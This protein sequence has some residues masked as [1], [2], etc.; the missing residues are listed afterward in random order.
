DV[1]PPTGHPGHR[2]WLCHQQGGPPPDAHRGG[3][4]ASRRRTRPRLHHPRR[5]WPRRSAGHSHRRRS[6]GP[7]APPRRDRRLLPR[8][9]RRRHGYRRRHLQGHRV[10]RRRRDDRLAVGRRQRGARSWL[11]LGD[12]H[13]PSDAAARRPGP[14]HHPGHA[15]GDPPR[16]GQRERR[17]AEPV[18]RAA[19]LDGDLRL[20]RC[21]GVPEGRGHGGPGAPD[22]GQ[23]VAEVPGRGDGPL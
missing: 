13:L 12:G 11:P 14:D 9:R 3:R 21:E 10:W 20:R 23:G 8:H 6:G 5:A 16:P 4:C 1:H 19:Y 18:W 2:G 7:H 22:R 15:G 17:Q